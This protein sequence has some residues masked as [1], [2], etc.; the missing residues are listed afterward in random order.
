MFSPDWTAGCTGCSLV[1]DHIPPLDHLHSRN[2]SFVAVSRA[3][4]EKLA[5][6]AEKMSWTFPWVSTCIT[7][8]T[9]GE[10]R[11]N[12]FNYDF[13]ATLD[14]AVAPASYN[15][16]SDEDMEA[17]GQTVF[18]RGDQP[19]LS[20]FIL[21]ESPN[22]PLSSRLSSRTSPQNPESPP[23]LPAFM[24]VPTPL[25]IQ[26]YWS[27]THLPIRRVLNPKPS[28]LTLSSRSLL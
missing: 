13:H 18:R 8:P 15:Y 14:P 24:P 16:R 27:A 4:V 25:R 3:P 7:D 9:T 6:Y 21:G 19:G 17:K 5:A 12:G 1:G 20:C 28:Q 23:G 26:P 22:F 11:D 2:T 10:T